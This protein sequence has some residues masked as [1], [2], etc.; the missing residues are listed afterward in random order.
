L[1]SGKTSIQG[2]LRHAPDTDW[3]TPVTLLLDAATRTCKWQLRDGAQSYVCYPHI[4]SNRPSKY[5][6]DGRSD[7]RPLVTYLAGISKTECNTLTTDR[8]GIGIIIT[9]YLITSY[10]GLIDTLKNLSN[11]MRSQRTWGHHK[12]FWDDNWISIQWIVGLSCSSF[13]VQQQVVYFT[14]EVNSLLACKSCSKLLPVGTVVGQ[15]TSFT[16]LLTRPVLS[17]LFSQSRLTRLEAFL[18]YWSS[19]ASC[20]DLSHAHMQNVIVP[21]LPAYFTM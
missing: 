13:F 1:S 6:H 10:F 3:L 20:G 19:A 5:R 12:N 15:R 11:P 21:R 7:S 9:K 4:S 18:L 2:F 17:V 16:R 14:R 8:R